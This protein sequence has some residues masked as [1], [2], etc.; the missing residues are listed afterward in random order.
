MRI[1]HLL[2]SDLD[3]GAHVAANRLHK[4]LQLIGIDSW[5][6]VDKKITDDPTVIGPIGFLQKIS[7]YLSGRLDSLPDRLNYDLPNLGS[8]YAWV[9]DR[10]ASKVTLIKP[11]LINLHWIND[12]YMRI[13]SL[14]KFHDI[15]IVWTLHDMWPF[16]GIKHYS[17]DDDRYQYGYSSVNRPISEHG[18]DFN[19][20]VWQRK[21]TVLKSLNNL[22]VV[23]PSVWMSKCAEKSV[24]FHDNEIKVIP[25]GVNQEIL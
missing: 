21:K 25:Y 3:G 6:I 24:I 4:A 17:T 5:M 7:S 20:W 11:D 10:I 13:E 1:V 2:K 22:T 14:R 9:P 18:I 16:C 23:A 8:S 19:R 15:P 12:G